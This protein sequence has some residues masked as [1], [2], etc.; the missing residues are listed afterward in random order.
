MYVEFKNEFIEML[1]KFESMW[2][3]HYHQET[4]SEGI[5]SEREG[6][7]FCA[8]TGGSKNR[9]FEKIKIEEILSEGVR[10]YRLG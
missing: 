2:N 6:N 10:N 7:L 3:G 1:T 8:V 5:P 9:K 4:S